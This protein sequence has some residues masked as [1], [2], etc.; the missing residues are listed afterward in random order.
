MDYYDRY[1]K[2][3]RLPWH[4]IIPALVM[5]VAVITLYTAQ[6]KLATTAQPL[7]EHRAHILR[8][9]S[10]RTQHT[11]ITRGSFVSRTDTDIE[12]EMELEWTI[13][14]LSYSNVFPVSPSVVTYL[15]TLDTYTI[16]YNADHPAQ[17]FTRIEHV[18]RAA[19]L[20]AL[21]ALGIAA[22]SVGI[23]VIMWSPKPRQ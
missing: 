18:R 1:E 2:T 14:G 17:A 19:L 12:A 22:V 4:W 10:Y 6:Q 8:V 5:L 20:R 7:L 11:R 16:H 13:D 15:R 21:T 23:W 9:G 3:V